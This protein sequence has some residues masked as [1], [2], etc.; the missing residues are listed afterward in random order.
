MCRQCEAER[1]RR[2]VENRGGNSEPAR[3]LRKPFEEHRGSSTACSTQRGL[4]KFG[5][6]S[7]A[8]CNAVGSQSISTGERFLVGKKKGL[9]PHLFPV[10]C[11]GRETL[12][13]AQGRL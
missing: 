4:L 1:P 2:G 3:G 12:L 10:Y 11:R 13:P 7:D 6:I 8:V 5:G 9:N